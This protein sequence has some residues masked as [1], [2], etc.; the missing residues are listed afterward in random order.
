MSDV[1]VS[2]IQI[3][4][5]S[6]RQFTVRIVQDP[7]GEPFDLTG[8]TEMKA[9][10]PNNDPNAAPVEISMTGGQITIVSAPQGKVTLFLSEVLTVNLQAG[11][12]QN[13]EMLITISSQ[14]QIVQ[15]IGAL[16]IVERLFVGV[17]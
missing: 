13:F 5:G 3:N 9:I 1:V 17:T 6:D 14:R 10:F 7:S 16:K 4:K 15:F 8:V 2:Q 12:S 11:D